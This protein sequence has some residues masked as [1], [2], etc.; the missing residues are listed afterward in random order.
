MDGKVFILE[1]SISNWS[2]GTL[3][4]LSQV[5][6]EFIEAYSRGIS[7]NKYTYTEKIC[8][9]GAFIRNLGILGKITLFAYY[10]RV[11]HNLQLEIN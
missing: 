3:K 9:K 7:V 1:I 11:F 6:N 8:V 5:F 2:L 10:G 4:N